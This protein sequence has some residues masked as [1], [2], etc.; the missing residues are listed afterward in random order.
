MDLVVGFAIFCLIQALIQQ[1]RFAS[2]LA[3][4]APAVGEITAYWTTAGIT[5]GL[6]VL[7]FTV[8]VTQR[9]IPAMVVYPI[10]GLI[11][12]GTIV[13]L[14]VPQIGLPSQPDDLPNPGYCS[15]TDSEN[16][17]GG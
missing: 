6:L 1:W 2:L 7:G 14:S 4:S 5:L 8:A 16:C 17:L 12:L 15:R 13:L 9:R 11:A 3:T 10:V